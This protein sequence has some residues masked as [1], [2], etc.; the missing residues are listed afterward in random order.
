ML[1]NILRLREVRV[2]DVMVPRADIE[3]VEIDI[4]LGDLLASFEKSGH[5]RMPVYR[6]TLDDPVGLRPHQ[7][8]D[9]PHH[10]GRADRAASRQTRGKR[11]QSPRVDLKR[12]DLHA[13]ALRQAE[14]LRNILFVPPSMPVTALLAK[15]AGDA[16]CRWRWSSTSMAAPTGWSRSR[17]SSRWSSATSRTSMTTRSGPMIVPDGE[18]IFLAD[19][20]RRARRGLRR[21]SASISPAARRA[22]RSTRVG[23]LVFS[24]LGRVPVRGEL[25][26]VPDGFEFEILDAD[27]RRIKRL[28][29]HTKP[30]DAARRGEP[31]RR[32]PPRRNAVRALD[33]GR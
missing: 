8:P 26:A 11:R 9:G 2:E 22:R 16:A 3:A 27:P 10:R 32:K 31:R 4:T 20:P 33:R 25:V 14:L 5:S 19:A 17:T 29:I 6:E 12:V 21:R 7:G 30:S 28:R 1:A 18:G 15:H 23:G 13:N 24:P